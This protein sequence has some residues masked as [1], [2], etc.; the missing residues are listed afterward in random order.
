MVDI[1]RSQLTF[2]KVPRKTPVQ[3]REIAENYF[4]IHD[5]SLAK[6][7]FQIVFL[8]AKC[9]LSLGPT[10]VFGHQESIAPISLTLNAKND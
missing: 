3:I 7:I 9:Y 1:Y 6:I 5:R 4:S 10:Y 2:P 8:F